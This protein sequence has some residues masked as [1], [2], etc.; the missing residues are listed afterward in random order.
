VWMCV[1]TDRNK[2]QINGPGS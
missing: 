1:D 2:F